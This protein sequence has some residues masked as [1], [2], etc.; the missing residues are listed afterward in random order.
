MT[1]RRYLIVNADDFGQSAGVNRGIIEAHEGGIVSSAS[2]MV[3]WP[4]ARQAAIYASHHASLSLGLHFDC[5]EWRYRNESWSKVYEVVPEDDWKAVKQEAWRQLAEFRRLTGANPTH[6]DSHQ[7]IHRRSAL[8]SIFLD[9][10]GDLNVPLRS[11]AP[12]IRYYGSFYGQD[13]TGTSLPELIRV[14][15]L[16]RTLEQLPPGFTEL[17]CHPGYAHGLDSMYRRERAIEVDTLCDPEVRRALDRN[18]IELRTFRD[19]ACVD[20][21]LTP[22]AAPVGLLDED[23][24]DPLGAAA[25]GDGGLL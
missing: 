17:G 8:E 14:D 22:L 4:A 24:A 25:S 2:L 11:Y 13:K 19:L 1:D 16:I 3:R 10:A 21:S 23:G 5:G 6:V 18:G 20:R 15:A 12:N 7:H 9:M